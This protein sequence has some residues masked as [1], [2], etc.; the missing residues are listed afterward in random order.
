MTTDQP[1]TKLDAL[2]TRHLRRDTDDGPAAARVFAALSAKQLPRQH[3]WLTR[4]WP[5]ILLE[6]DFTPAWPRVAALAGCA[7]LGFLI[8]IAGLDGQF[9]PAGAATFASRGDFSAF[10]FDPEPL[11]GLRP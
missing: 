4:R 9:D 11:T 3:G 5:N 8:G 10:T 1:D 7:A 2:L 6:W